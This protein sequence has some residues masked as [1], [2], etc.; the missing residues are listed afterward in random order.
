M[1]SWAR[2]KTAALK[3]LE[4][5]LKNVDG[6]LGFMS[7]TPG[8]PSSAE[9]ALYAAA[10]VFI[11]GIWENYCEQLAIELGER[12]AVNTAP[13]DVP[14]KVQ[15]Q[16]EK[17][18]AWE[19]SVHPGWRQLW[20]QKIETIAVGDGADKFGLNTAK[21]G[22][23]SHLFEMV[24]ITSPFSELSDDIPPDHLPDSCT[25][26]ESAVNA[27]VELRG[28]I[29]HTGSVPKTLRKHHITEWREFLAELT[30]E[31]DKEC[32]KQCRELVA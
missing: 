24:G 1:S 6:V 7:S 22:Q 9:R 16:L 10:V 11:Y 4:K 19:L 29:V 32:R 25:D 2:C 15:K 13:E 8:Q 12:V 20:V 17:H 14:A 3:N 21:A 26:V 30:K 23:V 27:L 18:T 31:L 5:S 28:E